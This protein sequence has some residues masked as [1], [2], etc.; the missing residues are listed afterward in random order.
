MYQAARVEGGARAVFH[1][2]HQ[3]RPC[4]VEFGSPCRTSQVPIGSMMRSHVCR[5]K[6]LMDRS[7]AVFVI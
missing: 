7:E 4:D 5:S 3:K 1:L 2:G 6:T